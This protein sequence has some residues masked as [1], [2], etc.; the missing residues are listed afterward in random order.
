M[1]KDKAHGPGRHSLGHE[2]HAG[3]ADRCDACRLRRWREARGLTQAEAAHLIPSRRSLH[4]TSRTWLRWERAEVPVP[5]LVL[6]LLESLDQAPP[7]SE[8]R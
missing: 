6:R 7:R 8:R 5:I 2:G 1:G 4:T 3:R